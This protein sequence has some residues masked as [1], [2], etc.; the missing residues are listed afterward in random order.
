MKRVDY[1]GCCGREYKN[2]GDW[3]SDCEPHLGPSSLAPWDR[4]YCAMNHGKDCP[5]T[6]TGGSAKA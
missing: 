4:T 3:C 1:C 2:A 6:E 5:F